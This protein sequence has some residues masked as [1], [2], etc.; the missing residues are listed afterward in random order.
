MVEPGDPS[1]GRHLHRFTPLPRAPAMDQFGLVQ[2]VDGLGQR[3]VV[4][5]TLTAD[6]WRD[7]GLGKPLAVG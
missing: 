5:I 6:R 1:Q 3:V 7:A 4:A 2:S